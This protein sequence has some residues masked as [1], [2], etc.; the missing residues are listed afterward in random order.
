MQIYVL[1]FDIYTHNTAHV[2]GSYASNHQSIRNSWLF[3]PPLSLLGPFGIPLIITSQKAFGWGRRHSM[4]EATK[5]LLT[6]IF[7][8]QATPGPSVDEPPA[9]PAHEAGHGPGPRPGPCQEGMNS[10]GQRRPTWHLFSRNTYGP[11][12]NFYS[13]LGM[14]PQSWAFQCGCVALWLPK[15]SSK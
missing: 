8:A 6:I 15:Q 7:H 4:F 10:K 11:G 1:H 12:P 13:P 3:W 9:A 5:G 14:D 2:C